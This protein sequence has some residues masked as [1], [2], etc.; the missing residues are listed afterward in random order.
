VVYVTGLDELPGGA[1]AV[2][3]R[4]PVDREALLAAL[5]R[6]IGTVPA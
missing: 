5:V 6:G 3:L 1:G 2:V 4:K